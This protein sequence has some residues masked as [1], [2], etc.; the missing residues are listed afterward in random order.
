MGLQWNLRTRLSA[1][2]AV[3]V[4]ASTVLGGVSLFSL[5]RLNGT[6]HTMGEQAAPQAEAAASLQTGFQK[7]R[8]AAHA[9][10]ISIV[11]GLMNQGSKHEGECIACHDAS[12]IQKGR[13]AFQAASGEVFR[14]LDR[15][16]RLNGSAEQKRQV[17]AVRQGAEKWIAAEDSYHQRAV[18]GAFDGAHALVA[19]KIFPLVSENGAAAAALED[20]AMQVLH[21]AVRRTDSQVSWTQAA[22]IVITLLTLVVGMGAAFML[23][24]AGRRLASVVSELD[25]A[26]ATVVHAGGQA[27]QT[28]QS[29]AQSATGQEQSFR[30][31]TSESREIAALAQSNSRD[32]TQADEVVSRSAARTAEARQSLQQML[33]S[34]EAVHESSEQI[35]KIIKIIDGIAFQTNILA[36][37]AAVEAA[38]AGESGLGFA[39]VADEVRSLAYR[40]AEAAKETAGL[41]E[42]LRQRATD[43]HDRVRSA[44]ESVDAIAED[45]EQVRA[46][47]G[48]VRAGSANQAAGMDRLGRSLLSIENAT[49]QTARSA[50]ESAA[51]SEELNRTSENL[52]AAVSELSRLVGV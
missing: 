36:L 32:V 14:E 29:L 27:A 24:D 45:A 6:L 50:D 16:A 42:K 18:G 5:S 1:S 48:Q 51:E 11:I 30:Q 49:A 40:C 23:R 28:S 21:E 39:A 4:A 33:G 13:A 35:A 10:Q 15:L 2:S 31:T 12:M 41:I 47:V 3:L 37:N 38:R 43:G 52:A 26:A 25:G 46:L 7:M 19:D 8:S 17:A 34:I 9:A 44:V 20:S 22:V